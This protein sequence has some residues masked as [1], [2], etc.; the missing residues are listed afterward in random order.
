MPGAL[1]FNRLGDIVL[2]LGSPRFGGEYYKLFR[3]TFGVDAC[4]VFAFPASG[5]PTPLLVE[6][7][8]RDRRRQA[9]HL[10]HD[11][12]NGAFRHDPIIRANLQRTSRSARPVVYSLCADQVKDVGYRRRLLGRACVSAE[13]RGSRRGRRDGLLLEFLSWLGAPGRQPARRVAA[14]ARVGRSRRQGVAAS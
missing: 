11:Y 14:D 7:D 9:W 12:S 13:T 3:D 8:S 6:C 1:A 2:A 5:F 4:T 10:A